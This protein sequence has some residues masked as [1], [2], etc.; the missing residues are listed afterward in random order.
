MQYDF[1][2]L[3]ILLRWLSDYRY[4]HRKE[5]SPHLKEVVRNA[6][7][8]R[9]VAV[10]VVIFP[11]LKHTWNKTRQ[12]Y[13]SDRKKENTICVAYYVWRVTRV[14]ANSMKAMENELTILYTCIAKVREI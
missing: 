8:H 13:Y 11:P 9:H 10:V 4:C 14:E 1:L 7:P 12:R 6:L 3:N 5:E 2:H